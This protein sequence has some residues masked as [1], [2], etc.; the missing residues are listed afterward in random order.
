MINQNLSNQSEADEA[1][2]GTLIGL[3]VCGITWYFFG[4]I[5]SFAVGWLE[6]ALYGLFSKKP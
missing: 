3:I 5:I 2:M 6:L 1:L 4:F